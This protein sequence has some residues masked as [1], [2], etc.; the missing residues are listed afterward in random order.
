MKK[1]IAICVALLL[2]TPMSL[3]ATESG[4]GKKVYRLKGSDNIISKTITLTKD[5][6][7]IEASRGVKVVVEERTGNDI[8]IYANDNIMPYVEVEIE[9]GE[10]EVSIDD[11]VNSISNVQVIV[12]M[13][14]N[15]NITKI[16]AS[17]AAK[18]EVIPTISVEAFVINASSAAEVNFARANITTFSIDA[19]SSADIKG[20]I[21]ADNGYIEASSASDV[22]VNILALRC[23]AKASSSADINIEGE[24]GTLYAEASSAAKI[25]AEK[26]PALEMANAKASSAGKVLVNAA[27]QLTAKASSGGSVRYTGEGRIIPETSS[28]GSIKPL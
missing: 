5:Y 26:C 4:D 24:V 23:S 13:P 16:E 20:I 28:G 9:D 19:S 10:L 7:K 3:W 14:A 1:I 25:C 18:V 22:E 15:T 27:K 6:T 12:N 2:T 8:V 11:D 17:S 21:K